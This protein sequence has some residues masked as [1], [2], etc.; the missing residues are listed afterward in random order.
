MLVLDTFTGYLNIEDTGFVVMP[1]GMSSASK[2][3]Q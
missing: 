1:G 2:Y 3:S